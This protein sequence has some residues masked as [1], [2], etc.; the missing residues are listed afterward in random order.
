[1]ES[2]EI[3]VKQRATSDFGTRFHMGLEIDNS[4]WA[5]I[6]ALPSTDLCYKHSLDA[7]EMSDDGPDFDQLA[8]F[9][10][11]S[12]HF[13]EREIANYIERNSHPLLFMAIGTESD[14][15]Q[16]LPESAR[17]FRGDADFVDEELKKYTVLK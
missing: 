1:M 11:R 6:P 16:N 10:C 9:Y 15:S 7:T 14:P 2:L 8:D 13:E 12:W 4:A 5:G 17:Y 3:I